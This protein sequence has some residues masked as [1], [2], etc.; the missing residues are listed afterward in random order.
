M[1]VAHTRHKQSKQ[2]D[3]KEEKKNDGDT[4]VII[5]ASSRE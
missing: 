3:E 4:R 2:Q 1:Y 5:Q